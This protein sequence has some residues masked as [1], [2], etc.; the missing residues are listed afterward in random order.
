MLQTLMLRILVIMFEILIMLCLRLLLW[1]LWLL[2][3][4]AINDSTIGFV[5]GS[6]HVA[7][8]RFCSYTTIYL[9]SLGLGSRAHLSDQFPRLITF[10]LKYAISA[11][12]S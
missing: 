1:L 6:A 11:T 5:K 8:V 10:Y 4:G 3:P 2:L 9:L 12:N 7:G